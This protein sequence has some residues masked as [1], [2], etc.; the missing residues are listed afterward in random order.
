[1]SDDALSQR[2]LDH[3]LMH[4]P[5]EVVLTEFSNGQKGSRQ[6]YPVRFGSAVFLDDTPDEAY[7]ANHFKHCHKTPMV[8]KK[9]ANF[10]LNLGK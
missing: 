2:F 8:F 3:G 9:G 1:M 7:R 6:I 4:P 5:C 10:G